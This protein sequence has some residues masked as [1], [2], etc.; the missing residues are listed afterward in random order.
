MNVSI[1]LG[2]GQLSFDGKKGCVLGCHRLDIY[3]RIAL[4]S[5]CSSKSGWPLWLPSAHRLLIAANLAS[6]PGIL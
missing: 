3:E 2:R 4:N 6:E 5:S 1:I